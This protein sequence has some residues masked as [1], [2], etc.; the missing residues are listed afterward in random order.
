MSSLGSAI[1]FGVAI[2]VTMTVL[3]HL[4]PVL[5]WR[6]IFIYAFGSAVGFWTGS[7]LGR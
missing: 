7:R 5:T 1:L 2:F 3:D 4:L 6:Q